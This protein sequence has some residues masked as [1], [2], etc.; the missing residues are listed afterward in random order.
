MPL[1]TMADRV[2]NR[3][4][5]S[6]KACK[7]YVYVKRQPAGK[8]CRKFQNPQG[9]FPG[10]V[11]AASRFGSVSQRPPSSPAMLRLLKSDGLGLFRRDDWAAGGP[12]QPLMAGC[13]PDDAG[14][15]PG[16]NHKH[17]TYTNNVL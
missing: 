1:S 9:L 11:A 14:C 4:L 16:L 17:N 3:P 6:P 8:Y 5:P 10:N 12:P 7:A 15:E 2:D 13:L